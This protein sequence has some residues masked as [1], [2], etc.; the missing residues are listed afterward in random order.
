M[1]Y[2]TGQN[3]SVARERCRPRQRPRARAWPAAGQGPAARARA[4]SP[5][6]GRAQAQ[7][8]SAQFCPA[9]TKSVHLRSAVRLGGVQPSFVRPR[10]RLDGLGNGRASLRRSAQKWFGS[11]A[12][13]SARP[14]RR[15]PRMAGGA[16]SS[17]TDGVARSNRT[18]AFYSRSS[19]TTRRDQEERVHAPLAEVRENQIDERHES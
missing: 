10:N 1:E 9:Q 8:N 3:T 11:S 5:A 2:S 7:S 14:W 6:R 13:S 16:F 4:P 17:P 15:P 12:R 19:T 18:N